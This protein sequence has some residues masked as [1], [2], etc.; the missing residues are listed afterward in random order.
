MIAFSDNT[1]TNMIVDKVG[2]A[3]INEHMAA[4]G[5]AE[6]RLNS[7]VYRRDTSVAPERSERFGLGSTTANDM[8]DLLAKIHAGKV[9]SPMAC[10]DMLE[11]LAACDD[12]LKFPAL[13]PEGTKVFH[14]T[15]SVDKVRTDAGIIETSQGSFALCVLTENNADT[16]WT[17][18][19]AG[20]KLCA[21]VAKVTFDYFES[22]SKPG[23]APSLPTENMPLALGAT[24]ERVEA[25][26]RTLN[27]QSELT[28]KLSVDGDFGPAT[29]AAV[30]K[31]QALK[32]LESSGQV[33]EATWKALGPLQ[34]E[35]A[36][37]PDPALST[38]SN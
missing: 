19:N 18:D 37:V 7:K 10:K 32:G 25:L 13:L 23:N 22:Q 1:A 34:F 15:G 9:V 24:G 20:D 12:K 8:V 33:N 30:K 21:Q 16:R 3:A 26:Q 31:F 4:L 6:T 35:D 11:H 36:P 28:D 38:P 27:A 2:I 29:E 17:P 5:Y 14:K